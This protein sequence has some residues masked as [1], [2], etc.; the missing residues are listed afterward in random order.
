MAQAEPGTETIQ[1]APVPDMAR[2]EPGLETI[3]AESEPEL[4]NVESG[5]DDT[6]QAEAAPELLQTEIEPD[7]A[8]EEPQKD[9]DQ[10]QADT[11]EDDSITSVA[12]PVAELETEKAE[13][14][15][16]TP[17]PE[18]V[19]QLDS[20]A[21]AT[22]AEIV[23]S[24]L[25][26]AAGGDELPEGTPVEAP[27]APTKRSAAAA[28]EPDRESPASQ[29][30]DAESDEAVKSE[31]ESTGEEVGSDLEAAKAVFDALGPVP[32]ASTGEFKLPE[33]EEKEADI[34]AQAPEPALEGPAVAAES[35]ALEEYDRGPDEHHVVRE[36]EEVESPEQGD[37]Q[38]PSEVTP[39]A[40]GEELPIY[41]E[42]AFLHEL[43]RE[44]MM[45]RRVDRPLTLIL[46]RI[47]DLG[48]IVEL[49]GKDFR[50][51]VMR[52]VAIQAI[53]SLREVDIVGLLETKE[54]LALT[55]FASDRYGGERIVSRLQA[56][57]GRN[58]FQVGE[59]IPSF[60]PKL[61]FGMAA[62]PKEAANSKELLER[63]E[64]EVE[65]S[66]TST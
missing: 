55:A 8:S 29:E 32:G 33:D 38:A 57:L 11:D 23:E 66:S 9:S 3:Q 16:E 12:S 35:T 10:A 6:V 56:T 65:P 18:L 2:A 41:P 46:I 19:E 61:R 20:E 58:P 51:K 63:A 7:G 5:D 42:E 17:E 15:P 37:G 30:P 49:F 47:A 27:E 24:E 54:L 26:I 53:E 4:A 22:L 1:A 62:Y 48:Q 21:N 50:P 31:A 40:V 52:H 44:V 60:I 25:D 64:D 34:K 28:D 43:R 13:D 14:T 39:E 36:E 45:C 59:G